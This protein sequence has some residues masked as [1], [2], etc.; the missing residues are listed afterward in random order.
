MIGRRLQKSVIDSLQAF[1]VVGIVGSRQTGKT[2]LAKSIAKEL[3]ASLYLDL[4]LPSDFNK[5]QNAELFLKENSSKLIIIDEVQRMPI[6]FPIIR[7]LVDQ[8]RKPARF[9]ILGSASPVFIKG[10]SESLAGRI[11][12]HE[13]STF[14]IDE[15]NASSDSDGTD[16]GSRLV[17]ELWLKGGY[18]LSYLNENNEESFT[19]RESF[20]KTFLEQDIPQLGI[21]IPAIQLRRF[22]TILAHN[23][24]KL[25]NSSHTALSLGVSAPTVKNYL[26]ILSDT[27]IVRQ[28]TPYFANVKKRIVKAAKTYVRDSGLL[29]ALLGIR[30]LEQLYGNPIAGFSWEGFIVEQIINLTR[31]NYEHY[32]YRTG[33][34]AEIDLLLVKNNI[35]EIAIEI[36]F[37]LE[38]KIM[39]GFWTSFDELKCKKGFVIYPGRD[40]Y[41]IH[42]K[43]SVTPLNRFLELIV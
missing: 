15:L 19:W 5:L 9:L 29:H 24:G 36:K 37:S 35:P 33:A 6:L 27:F 32:F 42:E 21:R 4:E 41:P 25:W 11:I 7:A 34:G 39:K 31:N 30:S 16:D 17:N 40:F 1:P 43:V 18:P 23:H 2:T 10:A 28:L 38:P 14:C 12:Y 8:D 3:P 26:D 13:L 20:I 22:W